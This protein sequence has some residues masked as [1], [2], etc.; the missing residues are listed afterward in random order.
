MPSFAFLY[1][2]KIKILLCLFI[3]TC[4]YQPV[5]GQRNSKLNTNGQG[6][7]FAQIGYNRSA[8]SNSDVILNSNKYDIVLNSTSIQDNE[9]GSG[10]GDFFSGSS[11][12]INI[13]LGYFIKPKWA[14]TI[15]FDRYNTYF[16]N[17]QRVELEGTFAPGSHSEYSGSVNEEI[18]LTRDQFNIAQSSGI[19]FLSIGVQRNDL[20]LKSRKSE[21]AFHTLYGIQVGPL[22]TQVDYTFDNYTAPGVSSLSGIGVAASIGVRLEFFQYIYLQLELDG[23]I[24]NQ[25]NIR[26]SENESTAGEQVI[27]FISPSIQLGFN[28]FARPKNGCGT[29]PK[30]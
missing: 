28:V 22:I 2:M 15:G 30:W 16:Q 19:N 12:Q 24:L 13:K 18:I 7:L 8:Y 6:T 3:L 27:G 1:A 21:F 17:N 20:L 5:T 14:I 25:N 23:G 26:L 29:C 4:V 10:M 9:E 11:P